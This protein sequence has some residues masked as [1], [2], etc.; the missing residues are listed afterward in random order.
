M[1]L[2]EN[3]QF[4][5]ASLQDYADC[6]RRFQL[7]Y[8]RRVRWPAVEAEPALANERHMR[9][10]S[11]LHRLIHQHLLGIA[12]ER[13]S[14]TVDDPDL[15]RWWSNY[16]SHRP[17]DLPEERH[18]ELVLSISVGPRRLVA[19]YDLVAVSPG[20]RAVIVDWKTSQRRPRRDWLAERWQTRVYLY[21]LV[22]GGAE[23]NG[24]QA[25]APEQVEMIYWF[26][27]F[28]TAPERFTYDAE[29]FAADERRLTALMERITG[30]GADD[31][32]MTG[33]VWHCRFCCYRSLCRPG[34]AAGAFED[35][36][37]EPE[38]EDAFD[39]EL[40]LEQIA[41]IEY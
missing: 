10:G 21:L 7:K 31:F 32:P 37:Q 19:K 28:P 29:R 3:F 2:P 6:P 1:V 17:E 26:A 35:R 24:G 36:E 22:R 15:R 4:S 14:A 11:L 9:L 38:V 41:E 13:L 33:D 23:F 16:L 20:R 18:S 12:A 5:Q 8:V 30:A 34:V 27:G 39:F 25:L 40:D